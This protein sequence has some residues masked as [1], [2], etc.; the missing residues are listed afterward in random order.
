MSK[1]GELV[2][3]RV[4]GLTLVGLCLS[5]V[6]PVLAQ[7]NEHCTISILNRTAQVQPSGGLA[8]R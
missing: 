6:T 2:V 1:R 7:L 3:G 8:D 4:L 5:V